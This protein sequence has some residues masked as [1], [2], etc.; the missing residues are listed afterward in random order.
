[1]VEM[2]PIVGFVGFKDGATTMGG[3]GTIVKGGGVVPIDGVLGGVIVITS[4]FLFL[5]VWSVD[6]A[7]YPFL[8]VWSVDCA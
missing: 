7:Q 5:V 1:M 3:G 2:L 8:V 4:D 6:C